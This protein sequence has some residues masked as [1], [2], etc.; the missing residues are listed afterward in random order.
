MTWD[1]NANGFAFWWKDI[2]YLLLC[3]MGHLIG[4]IFDNVYGRLYVSGGLTMGT[5]AKYGRPLNNWLRFNTATQYM[6]SMQWP[7][8]YQLLCELGIQEYACTMRAV[9][10][11]YVCVQ[12]TIYW[13]IYCTY[14]KSNLPIRRY[15]GRR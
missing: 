3:L 1:P 15:Q 11:C 13:A 10:P 14:N 2:I 9:Y 5:S 12:L 6:Y 7:D 4:F 8:L